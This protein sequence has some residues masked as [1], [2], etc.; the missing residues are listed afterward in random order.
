MPECFIKFQLGVLTKGVWRL[1]KAMAKCDSFLGEGGG[2]GLA[3]YSNYRFK[4]VRSSKMAAK[5]LPATS[6][7]AAPLPQ[8]GVL[9]A[10]K[11]FRITMRSLI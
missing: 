11:I 7:S 5:P 4:Q 8:E 2:R 3:N 6:R 1:K 9:A 10:I